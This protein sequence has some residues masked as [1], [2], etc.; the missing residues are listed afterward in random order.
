MY[1][2]CHQLTKVEQKTLSTSLPCLEEISLQT[3]TELRKSLKGLLNLCKLQIVF[4]IQRKLSNVFCFKDRLPFDLLSGVVY[5]Y[6]CGGRSSPYHG[7]TD[8]QV[9]VSLGEHIGISPL[10][11]TKIKPSKESANRD[12]LLSSNNIPSFEEFTISVNGNN[13]LVLEIKDS[14][15]IKRDR[16]ILNENISSAKLF[17]I[18][19]SQHF[20]LFFIQKYC[21]IIIFGLFSHGFMNIAILVKI[22]F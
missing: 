17:L 14:L 22:K 2:K 1:I 13:K 16:P 10:T 8:R 21:L 4:K 18:E 12:H 20:N 11:F 19:N 7:E 3:R 6:T 9:K 15:F 5:K